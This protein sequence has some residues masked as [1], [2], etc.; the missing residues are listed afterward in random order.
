[1]PAVLEYSLLERKF[2]ES[3]LVAGGVLD[4]ESLS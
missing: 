3:G 4:I 2:E 1:V